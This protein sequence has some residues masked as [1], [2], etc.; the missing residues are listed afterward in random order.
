MRN[1]VDSVVKLGRDIWSD[2]WSRLWLLVV[3]LLTVLLVGELVATNPQVDWW[4]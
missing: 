2:E 1:I 4:Q 3:V